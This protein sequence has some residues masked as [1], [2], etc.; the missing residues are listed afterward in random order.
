MMQ[1]RGEAP[2]S[3][4]FA[5]G[6]LAGIA[7]Y[8]HATGLNVGHGAPRDTTTIM[9]HGLAVVDENSS[10]SHYYCSSQPSI[11]MGKIISP[12]ASSLA[13]ISFTSLSKSSNSPGVVFPSL[14]IAV[15]YTTQA[16]PSH[17]K[18]WRG[19]EPKQKHPRS[20][21]VSI[22]ESSEEGFIN[23]AIQQLNNASISTTTS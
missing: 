18:Q 3:T 20:S 15:L 8:P 1:P 14:P 9:I 21:S 2:D 12:T 7:C 22:P 5:T 19:K 17:K 11:F 4:T 13:A 16:S 23:E 10:H 6:D